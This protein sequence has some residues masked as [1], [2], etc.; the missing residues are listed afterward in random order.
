MARNLFWPAGLLVAACAPVRSPRVDSVAPVPEVKFATPAS[1]ESAPVTVAPI[2]PGDST[3]TTDA[4]ALPQPEET[5]GAE[6]E[7][8]VTTQPES[9]DPRERDKP[10]P[11]ERQSHRREVVIEARARAEADIEAG[12]PRIVVMGLTSADFPDVDPTTGFLYRY[13]GCVITSEDQ[14]LDAL[15]YNA[16]ILRA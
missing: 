7:R 14:P 10:A 8:L 2:G 1:A 9:F 6:I 4:T 11:A 3:P 13:L 15:A 12:S 16:A 5:A